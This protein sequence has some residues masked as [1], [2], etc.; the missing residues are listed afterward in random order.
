MFTRNFAVFF[1]IQVDT[2]PVFLIFTHYIDV[3][4]TP[5]KVITELFVKKIY[6]HIQHD[7][8]LKIRL[9]IDI[10]NS[11]DACFKYPV[12]VQILFEQTQGM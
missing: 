1:Q 8:T 12:R 10:I 11:Y 6:M 4:L 9:D 3:L 2:W 5:L 7:Y